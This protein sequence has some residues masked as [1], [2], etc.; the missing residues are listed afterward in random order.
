M[1]I[2]NFNISDAT[3]ISVSEFILNS[4]RSAFFI[5]SSLKIFEITGGINWIGFN[6]VV[7]SL[8]SF[9]APILAGLMIDKLGPKY[10]LWKTTIIFSILFLLISLISLGIIE[11]DLVIILLMTV[12]LSLATPFQKNSLFSLI[13]ILFEASRLVKVNALIFSYTQAGQF[14]GMIIA[15]FLIATISPTDFSVGLFT[16]YILIVYLYYPLCIN[17]KKNH[18]T[19]F[20]NSSSAHSEPLNIR[21]YFKVKVKWLTLTASTSDFIQVILFKYS[22]KINCKFVTITA[23]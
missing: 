20:E 12:T 16:C 18:Y 5:Y 9:A 4:F 11:D 13:K 23:Q 22:R 1:S 10:A 21:T 3:R 14:L 7:E 17:T 2:Q 6:I 8:A 15:P 19:E